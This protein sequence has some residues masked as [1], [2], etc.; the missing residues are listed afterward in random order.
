MLQSL[1]RPSLSPASTLQCP[2]IV[3]FGM[4]GW[5]V[6]N[7]SFFSNFFSE[8][9]FSFFVLNETGHFLLMLHSR[10]NSRVE[11]LFACVFPPLT[12]GLREEEGVHLIYLLHAASKLPPSFSF[13]CTDS[14]KFMPTNF[15]NCTLLGVSPAKLQPLP[16]HSGWLESLLPFFFITFT[17]DG[18]CWFSIYLDNLSNPLAA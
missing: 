18:S 8:H 14:L 16:F 7:P 3:P 11:S 2:S 6:A 1:M 5:L 15:I 10:Q 17:R 12:W 4:C 13:K 9:C